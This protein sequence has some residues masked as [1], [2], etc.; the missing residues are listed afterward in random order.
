MATQFLQPL[1]SDSSSG[2]H[3]DCEK[4]LGSS[5][6]RKSPNSNGRRSLPVATITTPELSIE[7][8]PGLRDDVLFEV[9]DGKF[10]E[11]SPMGSF[12]VEVASI[13]HEHLGPFVRQAGLGRAI[14]EILF[15]IDAKTQY[16]PDLAFISH[17]KW[18]I[19]R[20]SPNRRP[21]KIV[22]DLAIEVISEH[23]TA[24][25]VLKKV[26]VYLDAGVRAVWLIYPNLE[27]V[28]VYS[29]FTQIQVLTRDDVL[30]GGEIIPGFRLPIGLLFV[31]EIAEEDA[32]D[33]ED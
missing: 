24:W 2:E 10:V 30:D 7:S 27:V 18:P 4:R 28:H 16:R 5:M 26:R 17:E 23:D 1:A 13:L 9:I 25:E 19:S 29:S 14:V 12:P 3:F 22:P 32:M 20:R 33:P 11:M 31:G 15:R 6:M 8:I 21:W